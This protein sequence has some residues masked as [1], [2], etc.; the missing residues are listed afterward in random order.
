MALL[1][2]LSAMAKDSLSQPAHPVT[3]KKNQAVLK[4]LNFADRQD[5]EYSKKGF[6]ATWDELV[7]KD[8]KGEVVWNMGEI[9]YP[10]Y[11]VVGLFF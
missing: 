6:I 7:I 4:Y 3:A 8:D 5:F 2:P 1:F 9:G 11:L 10:E